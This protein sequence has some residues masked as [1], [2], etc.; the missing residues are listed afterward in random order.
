MYEMFVR[1]SFDIDNIVTNLTLNGI[2]KFIKRHTI[3][4][5]EPLML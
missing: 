5:K 4:V 3:L 1:V 2:P